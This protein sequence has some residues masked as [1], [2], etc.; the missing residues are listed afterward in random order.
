M[1]I[2]GHGLFTNGM[3]LQADNDN[4]EFAVTCLR[5]LG[6]G[7]DGPR[8]QALFIVDGEVIQTFD[9]SLK[10][11]LP[12]LLPPV[13]PAPPLPAMAMSPEKLL[14]LIPPASVGL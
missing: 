11:P 1:V 12:P 7:P 2:A 13:P 14:W 8:R 10:P 6:D 3:L 5:W 4:F 9:G